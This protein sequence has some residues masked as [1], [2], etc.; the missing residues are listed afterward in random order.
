MFRSGFLRNARSDP[1]A[2]GSTLKYIVNSSASGW[3]SPHQRSALPA[4]VR[5]TGEAYRDPFATV[6]AWIQWP[7]MRPHPRPLPDAH[8]PRDATGPS[9]RV[10]L[11]VS[12]RTGAAEGT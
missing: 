3:M 2:F 12:P 9:G 1:S 6:V 10:S 11:V 4:R 5:T 7:T 8:K